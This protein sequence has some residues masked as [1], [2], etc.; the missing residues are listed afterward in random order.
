MTESFLLPHIGL[1][2]QPR[3]ES[4]PTLYHCLPAALGVHPKNT[5]VTPLIGR[6]E[7]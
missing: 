6:Q 5:P 7:V 3:V 2:S 1:L 4:T